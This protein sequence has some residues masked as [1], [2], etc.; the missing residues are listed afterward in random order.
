V[1]PPFFLFD[2]SLTSS[3]SSVLSASRNATSDADIHRANHPGLFTTAREDEGARTTNVPPSTSREYLPSLEQ[4]AVSPPFF[5][6]LIGTTSRRRGS[7]SIC[8]VVLEGMAV[9]LSVA[10]GIASLT[11]LGGDD[12]RMHEK[13][14]HAPEIATK[15]V[16]MVRR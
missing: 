10:L 7:S 13:R 6:G 4:R 3:F 2:G 16:L 5:A 1:R 14:A 15:P 9:A 12:E 11:P 8:N